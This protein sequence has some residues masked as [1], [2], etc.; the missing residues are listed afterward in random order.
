MKQRG[1]RFW[2]RP[3]ILVFAVVAPIWT[4]F[5]FRSDWVVALIPLFASHML[6]LYP[7][8]NPQSQWW[9]SVIRAFETSQREVWITIDDG[10]TS[11]HTA[12]IL[13][14]LE[15]HRARATFFVVGLRAKDEPHLV[16]EILRSGHSVANHTFTHPSGSFWCAGPGR[17]ANEIDQC[18]EAISRNTSSPSPLFRAPAGLKNPFLHPAL[19][20]RR[21]LLI[22]WTVRGL[23]TWRRDPSAIAARI[24]RKA[25]PGAIILLHEGHYLEKSPGLNPRCLELTLQGLSK[26]GYQFVIPRVEQLR[27]TSVGK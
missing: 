14:I 19:A 11:A 16:E 2:I 26:N 10:P 25:L 23:D 6:L 9:G 21:M 7:T 24:L 20:R 15:R 13:E 1:S 4:I 22:G 27:T 12:K 3:A 18:D 17:M 5:W 8:L